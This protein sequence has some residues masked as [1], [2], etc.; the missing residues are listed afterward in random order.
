M[1]RIFLPKFKE[2]RVKPQP[3][4]GVE[5]RNVGWNLLA[6][7]YPVLQSSSEIL[8]TETSSRYSLDT[9][10]TKRQG[11]SSQNIATR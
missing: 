11:V 6:Q 1:A 10:K 8:V 3:Q 2:V 5:D 9:K 4:T 7:Q